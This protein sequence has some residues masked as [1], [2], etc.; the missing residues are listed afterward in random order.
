[1][2]E[3]NHDKHEKHEDH[4]KHEVHSKHESHSHEDKHEMRID[5]DPDKKVDFSKFSKKV[6]KNPWIVST[7]VLGLALIVLL[8]LNFTGNVTGAFGSSDV[9]G[10]D[11]AGDKIVSFLNEQT[12]GGVEYVSAEDKGN[13][14]EVTVAYNGQDVPV[15]VTKDGAYFVQGAIPMDEEITTPN[16]P[17]TTTPPA[18]T[19]VP[20]SDKP[21]VELF[22]MS[23][24][25]YGTQAEKGM[26][27][28]Y[29]LLGDNIDSNIRFVY[30]AMHGET[31]VV[32]QKNQYCI[33][34]EQNDKYYDYL[35]CFLGKTGS[36]ADSAACIKSVGINQA[37]L[38]TCAEKADKE[39]DLT[40]NLEDT[41]S[42]LS[43]R[44]PLFNI[45]KALNEEY[46]IGGSPTLVINGV[47]VSS[48]RDS[49]SYLA[50]VCNAFNEPPAE[51]D[52]VLSS[53]SPSA[54]FGYAASGTAAT[55]AQ[56]G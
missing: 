9:I 33:Q 18:A 7:V 31:E 16:T 15:Y 53:T 45:D 44:F 21:I 4:P 27:P 43:G 40:K 30:Y 56:C 37:K 19:N 29:E 24:C 14:Y 55:D 49:A 51:C 48:G 12:G 10:P 8:V 5:N 3:H 54:G 32:E 41:T 52:E 22:V 46:G 6:K 42:Y 28:V 34:K 36:A 13:L 47:T 38:T 1:M 26:L 35:K 23:H 20:K 17:S 25:P 50:A 11:V 39:F 2:E